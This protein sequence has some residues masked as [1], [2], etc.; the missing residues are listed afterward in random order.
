MHNATKKELASIANRLES[1]EV[2]LDNLTWVEIDFDKRIAA[3]MEEW[4]MAIA[5]ISR[6]IKY[7]L[8]D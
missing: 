3:R 8:N 4:C 7:E 5:D 1:M 6:D 2:L